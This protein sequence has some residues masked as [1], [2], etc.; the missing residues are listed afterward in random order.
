MSEDTIV[1][2]LA[3][4]RPA[5]SGRGWNLILVGV[6]AAVV[7]LI[8]RQVAR[9]QISEALD[10]ALFREPA[11]A[12]ANAATLGNVGLAVL[13]IGGALAFLCALAVIVRR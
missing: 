8:M 10:M 9:D 3:N 13:I 11:D 1:G 6:A 4:N 12:I 5:K 2:S 7:G